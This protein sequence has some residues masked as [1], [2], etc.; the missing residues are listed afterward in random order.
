[1][2]VIGTAGHVDHGK[3][4]LVEAITG[5]DP[6]RLREEKERAMTID[7]GFAWMRLGDDE[8]EEEVGIVDVPGHRDFIENMLAGV[9]GID[10]AL[11]VIAADEGVMPQTREHLAILDL[12]EVK[13]GV[14]ALSKVDLVTEPD[15]LELVV[16]DVVEVL[17]GTVLDGA[18]IV[19]VSAV[20]GQGLTELRLILAAKLGQT[21]PRPD[22]GRPRL[23][24]DRVFSLPGFGTI[25]TGTL[26]GGR[27]ALG[28]A[29]EIQ[30]SGLRARVR[31]LQTHKSKLTTA[32]PGSRVAVNLAGVSKDELQRGDVLAGPGVLSGTTLCDVSYRQLRDSSAPLKHNQEVKLFVGAAE[33]MA[34]TRIIGAKQIDPGQEGWLQLALMEPA[35]VL[36]GDRF[37]LRRPSPGATLGGGWILDPHPGRRYRRFRP[38][39]VARLETL[40]QGTAAERLLQAI[41]RLEPTA[42]EQALRQSA[43]TRAEADQALDELLR[44]DQIIMVGQVVF[45]EAGWKVA[46]ERLQRIVADFH[47]QQPLRL[48]IPR[49]EL[50]SRLRLAPAAFSALLERAHE[51]GIVVEAK[52]LVYLPGHEVRF[53]PAQQQA[54]EE[55]MQA[56]E[57]AGVN[58][59]SVKEVKALVGEDVY[60]ALLDLGALLQVSDEVVYRAEEYQTII[61]QTKR[62]LQSHQTISAAQLRDLLGTSRKY[63]IAI[64]EHLDQIKVTRRVGDER[65]LIG[66]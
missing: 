34:R 25:V 54:V 36:R 47:A 52:S 29:V 2:H 28:E 48:G 45:S 32:Q 55:L 63:A 6:D 3:S 61:G 33:L 37:I 46:A 5:I 51:Q 43:L 53:G 22:T 59:P 19:P 21:D 4:T 35:A 49:E 1:M 7:L 15:W 64:L 66:A 31:G 26:A 14:V 42:L 39:A 62:Y 41:Q 12:L 44:L 27:L 40:S 18:P 50:R 24:I 38:E 9:G 17:S 16:L 20:T 8:D 23:P 60:Y 58:S 30:P 10:L 11:L 13:G 65:Q 56:L 57:A